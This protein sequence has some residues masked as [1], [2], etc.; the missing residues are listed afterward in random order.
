MQSHKFALF[1]PSKKRISLTQQYNVRS[2]WFFNKCTILPRNY[3]REEMNV[4][5]EVIDGDIELLKS[6]VQRHVLWAGRWLRFD[7]NGN[8]RNPLHHFMRLNNVVD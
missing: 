6:E 3:L 8:V 1:C 5:L 7:K 2:A 4:C